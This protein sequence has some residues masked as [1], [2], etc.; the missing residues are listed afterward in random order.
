MN[1]ADFLMIIADFSINSAIF[2]EIGGDLIHHIL[3]KFNKIDRIYKPACSCCF[4][5]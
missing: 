3:P 4:I 5:M 1:I 2:L